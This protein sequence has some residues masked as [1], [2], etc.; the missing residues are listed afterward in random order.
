MAIA[1]GRASTG[2]GRLGGWAATWL[3]SVL[4]HL[5]IVWGF[6]RLM[7][8]DSIG[9]RSGLEPDDL[10]RSELVL[11]V[12]DSS[13][14]TLTWLG[15][16]DP[17]RHEALIDAEQEQAELTLDR[18]APTAP[19]ERFEEPTPAPEVSAAEASSSAEAGAIDPLP[20]EPRRADGL[21]VLPGVDTTDPEVGPSEALA[22]PER[23]RPR[24]SA[25]AEGVPGLTSD[26]EAPAV[27]LERAVQ[28]VLGRPVAAQ[29]L[30]IETRRPKVSN[31]DW[32]RGSARNPTI[33]LTYRADGTVR[34]VAFVERDGR[35][36][37]TGHPFVDDKVITA[38]Y[39]FTARGERIEA[40]DRGEELRLEMQISWR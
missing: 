36:L 9:V 31:W 10:D 37:S 22:V 11:G 13:A 38:A 6:G 27:S 20:L 40:L 17:T 14:T 28:V 29:G 1:G 16:E 35:V 18:A 15:F 21:A 24:V 12:D 5:M 39:D 23:S 19:V 26:R 3:L 25:P 7:M 4:L 32:V 33:R 8:S 30:Y 34:E 2:G